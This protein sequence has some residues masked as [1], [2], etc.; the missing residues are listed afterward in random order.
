MSIVSLKDIKK[1]FGATTVLEDVGFVLNPGD[2]AGL[3]GLNGCGKTTLLDIISGR[4]KPGSGSMAVARGTSIGYLTQLA[5]R[6]GNIS[7]LEEMLSTRPEVLKLKERLTVSANRVA[8]LAGEGGTD[9]EREMEEYGGLLDMFESSGGYAYENEVTGALTGLGFGREE[10]GRQ[11]GTLSGGE[12]TRLALGK[13]LMAGHQALLLDEPTNHLDIPAIMWLEEFL[14]KS[15]VT[16]LIVSHDRYFLDRV[17]TRVL[18]LSGGRVE[19]Y[20]GNFT[21]Y[22]A[23]KEKRQEARKKEY[24]LARAKYEK[25]K[26]YINRM[27]A[28]VNSK[29]AKGREKR[30]ERFELP[31]APERERRAMNLKF[32][33][34][35][36]TSDI[37]I[38]VEGVSKAFGGPEVLDGVSF[39]LRRGERAGIVGA[40]GSGK[41]TLLK[42][43]LGKETPDSGGACLGGNVQAGYYAQG[44]EGLDEKNT[45]LDELWSVAPMADEQVIRDALGAF[46]FSGDDS[47]KVVK[48]LSGGEKGRLAISKIVLAGANLL[49]LDEPTNHLDITSREALEAA[50][51][52]FDG[53]VLAVSHDRYFLDGFAQ[54]IFELKDGRLTEYWGNYTD[55]TAK[56]ADDELEAAREASEGRRTWEERKQVQALER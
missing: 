22:R 36:R 45:V 53:T 8:E 56:R 30:L 42:I 31:D 4:S 32:G 2:R 28:G 47:S 35:C 19:S 38:S 24:E 27:R 20:P 49:V 3:V 15:G 13:L 39:R 26:E 17:A 43:I 16:A 1:S 18:E 55:Y 29:Q 14:C 44:L 54:K 7:L 10:F 50:V 34:V 33:A 37:V 41:S 12:R 6:E 11:V 48:M 23:E 46:L 21:R 25:E 5:G 40:N 52:L 51:S 9:Y